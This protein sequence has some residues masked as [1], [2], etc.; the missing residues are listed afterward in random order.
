MSVMGVGA[1]PRWG[2]LMVVGVVVV[3]RRFS[4]SPGER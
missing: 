1:L 3:G 4:V 2:S